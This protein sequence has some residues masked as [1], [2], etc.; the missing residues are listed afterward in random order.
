M[1]N[2]P[3]V[4]NNFNRYTLTK[5]LAETLFDLG[6][7]NIH[8]LDNNSSYPRLLEW[9]ESYECKSKFIIKR[10]TE[11]LQALSLWNSDYIN[12]FYPQEQWMAYTDSDLV[13]NPKTPRN[14]IYVL[15]MLAEKYGVRKAGLALERDDLPDNLYGNHYREWE[16]RYWTKEAEIEKGIYKAAIDTTFA[17]IKPGMPFD[18]EA[19]RVAGDFTARH[20]PWYIDPYNLDEEETYYL[21]HCTNNSSYKRF[22]NNE[23]LRKEPFI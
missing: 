22:Y 4:I 8:I 18:Y 23:I 2:I 5:R 11:N 10:L 3:I 14:F 1:F 7:R 13:L 15:I 9:Y 20:E 6:Y 21:D 17:V 12:I 16:H 19:I